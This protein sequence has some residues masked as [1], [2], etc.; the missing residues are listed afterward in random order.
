MSAPGQRK[1]TRLLQWACSAQEGLGAWIWL[2]EISA[3]TIASS[4][5]IKQ[6]RW[7]DE[8]ENCVC[9][10]GSKITKPHPALLGQLFAG[11]PGVPGEGPAWP[12]LLLLSFHPKHPKGLG[13]VPCLAPIQIHLVDMGI[14]NN[15]RFFILREA[16][17][18]ESAAL[19]GGGGPLYR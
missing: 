9:S 6:A 8:M 7:V 12:G 18:V 4:Y 15:F 11:T 10:Q 2:S 1:G 17:T 19:C 3:G 13:G 14:A 5:L 16:G